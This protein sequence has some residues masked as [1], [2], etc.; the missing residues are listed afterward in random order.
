MKN[1]LLHDV[2]PDHER[3]FMEVPENSIKIGDIVLFNM[4]SSSSTST[5]FKHATV[6]C[7]EGEVIHFQNIEKSSKGR[8]SKEGFLIMRHQRGKCKVLRKREGFNHETFKKKVKELMNSTANYNLVNNNCIN[9]ALYLL[10]VGDFSFQSPNSHGEEPVLA[11]LT[12][13]EIV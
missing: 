5:I 3:I 12:H 6:Y 13:N 8:I 4:E 7:G 2:L 10:D 11:R 1:F 9:F